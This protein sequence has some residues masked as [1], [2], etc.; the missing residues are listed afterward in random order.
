MGNII[1]KKTSARTSGSYIQ[2]A[3]HSVAGYAAWKELVDGMV[4]APE[5]PPHMAKIK[6]FWA[7]PLQVRRTSRLPDGSPT[8]PRRP[9][10]APSALPRNL[11]P[12]LSGADGPARAAPGRSLCRTTCACATSSRIRRSWTRSRAGA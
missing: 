9:L 8:A 7:G 4:A 10:I 3:G 5:K 1:G 6:E 2:I 12:F 11:R